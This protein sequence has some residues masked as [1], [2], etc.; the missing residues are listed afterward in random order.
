MLAWQVERTRG[1]TMYHM[2]HSAGEESGGAHPQDKAP[3]KFVI[4]DE[5]SIENVIIKWPDRYLVLYKKRW[6]SEWW[7]RARRY[8]MKAKK[9]SGNFTFAILLFDCDAAEM[10]RTRAMRR[11]A[12]RYI[13]DA[14]EKCIRISDRLIL[15]ARFSPTCHIPAGNRSGSCFRASSPAS[16]SCSWLILIRS[17]LSR[18]TVSYIGAA[19][20]RGWKTHMGFLLS[21]SKFL[22]KVEIN[23]LS[24]S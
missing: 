15:P 20:W 3:Q 4:I 5:I 13:E 23:F 8:Q 12:V 19:L 9:P 21:E 11:T 22:M 7:T 6:V 17:P 10:R 1:C 2:R 24:K 16:I 18:L 14:Q